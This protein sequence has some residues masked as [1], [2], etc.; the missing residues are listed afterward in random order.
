[1][2]FSEK[3]LSR[4]L[5]DQAM[6]LSAISRTFDIMVICANAEVLRRVCP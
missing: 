6:A 2:K 1:L 4:S 5:V 3:S